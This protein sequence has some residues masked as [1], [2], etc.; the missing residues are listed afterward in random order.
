MN[1]DAIVQHVIAI[2]AQCD[3]LLAALGQC[4]HKRREDHSTFGSGERWRC[5]D[6]GYETGQEGSDAEVSSIDGL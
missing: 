4:D 5:L 2:R 3:A 1:H 6:C